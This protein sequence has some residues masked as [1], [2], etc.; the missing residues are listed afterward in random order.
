M[1]FRF[2]TIYALAFLVA[3]V[4][5]AGAA[6]KALTGDELKALVSN[7]KN[8]ILG[9]KGEGYSGKLSLNKDGTAKGKATPDGGK[10][11]T[12]EGT[13]KIKGDTFCRKWADLDKGKEVCETWRVKSPTQVEVYV[14]KSKSGVNSW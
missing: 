9:G 13:W 2:T 14:G 7:G 4:P 3:S 1:K 5:H 11:F 6:D 12:I 8:L 10:A